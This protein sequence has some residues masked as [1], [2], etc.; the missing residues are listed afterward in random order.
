MQNDITSLGNTNLIQL[1]ESAST[2]GAKI[3]KEVGLVLNKPALIT[4]DYEAADGTVSAYQKAVANRVP[5]A[6]ALA[7]LLLATRTW[8]MRAKDTLKPF[9]GDRHSSLWRP[10][11]FVTSLRVPED[12]GALLALVDKLHKYL[13][14][15]P[16]QTND[17]PKVNVTPERADELHEGLKKAK[18]D[19][20]EHDGFIRDRH[21]DQEKALAALRTRLQGLCGELKQLID[22]NDPRWHRFGLNAPG[23]PKTPAQPEEV[24]VNSATPGQLLVSCGTVPF[25]DRYRFFIQKA[26]T[27]GEPVAVGSSKNPLFLMEDLGV[28]GRYHV[29]VSAVN[30]AGN[31][32]PHSKAVAADV[33]AKAA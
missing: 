22:P 11:G 26:G 21:G 27:A 5:L 31:E 13:A 28:G 10:T 8:C 32:G 17:K 30:L 25:A 3:G 16:D 20:D 33:T 7:S 9:L 15:H 14:D 29:F 1:G 23:E 24:Q 18:G 4:D 19:L 6:V 12:Y 2:A